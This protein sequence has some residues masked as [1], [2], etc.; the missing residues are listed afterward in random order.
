V[1]LEYEQ[2]TA[3]ARYSLFRLVTTMDSKSVHNHLR[4]VGD[5]WKSGFQCLKIV[6]L[7]FRF[8]SKIR[9]TNYQV[10]WKIRQK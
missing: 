3:L 4:A 9:K 6:F 10:L 5:V 1:T 2:P 8:P 7:M